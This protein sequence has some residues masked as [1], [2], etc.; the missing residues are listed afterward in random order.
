[1]KITGI[2]V[3]S[4]GVDWLS[5]GIMDKGS[6]HPTWTLNLAWGFNIG[7]KG[8]VLELELNPGVPNEGTF[9]VEW[10]SQGNIVGHQVLITTDKGLI[11]V[12][13]DAVSGSTVVRAPFPMWVLIGGAAALVCL[14]IITKK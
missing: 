8:N 2:K 11:V 14:I 12:T 1:M 9:T 4:A 10:A 5:L 13:L 7:P 3:K 6:A